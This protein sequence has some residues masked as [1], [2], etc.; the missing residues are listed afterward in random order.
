MKLHYA[1]ACLL[2]LLAR[3]AG[4][5]DLTIVD[6]RPDEDKENGTVTMNAM[7]CSF[8]LSRVGDTAANPSKT[9]V[10]EEDLEKNPA[11]ALDG[12][13]LEITS[14]AIYRNNQAFFRNVNGGLLGALMLTEEDRKKMGSKCKRHKTKG[15]W[16]DASEVATTVPP[17]VSELKGIYDGRTIAVRIV[18]SPTQVSP[19]K[20][21]G[22]PG[23]TEIAL[24]AIHRTAEALATILH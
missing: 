22:D 6:S 7:S 11:L 18:Y 19:G 14:W 3:S 13:T 5:G 23:D 4:A 15:G 16:Y 20:F 21:E 10:L 2:A 17:L 9:K 8:G 12:K 1:C 24:Q